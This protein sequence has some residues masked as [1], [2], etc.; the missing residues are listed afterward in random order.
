MFVWAAV[1]RCRLIVRSH[2]VSH[3]GRHVYVQGKDITNSIRGGELIIFTHA[4]KF[5]KLSLPKTKAVGKNRSE[6]AHARTPRADKEVMLLHD[7]PSDIKGQHSTG[8]GERGEIMKARE[9][10]PGL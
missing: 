7:S 9:T 1:K 5:A 8:T 6:K 2:F 4:R 3:D 10:V